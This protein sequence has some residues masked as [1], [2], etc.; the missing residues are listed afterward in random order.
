MLLIVVTTEGRKMGKELV[1]V[2]A[3]VVDSVFKLLHCQLLL[4]YSS[5]DGNPVF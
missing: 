2:V 1:L 5:D 4:M 3:G